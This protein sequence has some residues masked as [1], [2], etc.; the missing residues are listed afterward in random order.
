MNEPQKSITIELTE[1]QIEQL[2]PVVDYL[3]KR[4]Y[5]NYPNGASGVLMGQIWPEKMEMKVAFI[6]KIQVD[7]INAILEEKNATDNPR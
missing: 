2:Q 6:P 3:A 5:K 1:D 7:K 4:N